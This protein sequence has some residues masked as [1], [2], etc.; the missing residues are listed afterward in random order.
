MTKMLVVDYDKCTGCR[1]CVLT[2]SLK[3][4]NTFNPERARI[5][6]VRREEEGILVPVVCQH[7]EEPPCM[8]SCPVDA[9][10]RN[11]ETGAVEIDSSLCTG[12]KIC[13]TECP[14]GG[15]SL[16]PVEDRAVLC[17]LCSG[18]P[19]CAESCPTGALQYVRAD[20][21]DTIR[22]RQAI[23]RMIKSVKLP[24]GRT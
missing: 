23:E 2:C 8:M 1:I 4:T 20:R 17:D 9:I 19:A 10:S 22:R 3:K 12:C 24:L 15:P 14:F 16:D 6:I 7:C 5:S 21:S 13:M 18:N 11:S